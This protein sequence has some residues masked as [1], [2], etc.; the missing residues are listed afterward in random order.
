MKIKCGKYFQIDTN[1][2]YLC[3]VGKQPTTAKEA[4][5]ITLAKWRILSSANKYLSHSSVLT[6]GLCMFYIKNEC[7]G[8][9]IAQDGHIYCSD[10]PYSGYSKLSKVDEILVA[11]K[12]EL[13]YLKKLYKKENE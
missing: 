2:K 10:T 6:C 13:K 1:K 7:E 5:R 9:P 11:A 12:A 8:C 4:W 3:F